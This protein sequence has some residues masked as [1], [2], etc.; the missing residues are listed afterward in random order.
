MAS[1]KI[2]LY[3]KRVMYDQAFNLGTPDGVLRFLKRYHELKARR[4]EGDM[5]A[6]V[7]LM[8][9]HRAWRECEL[10]SRERE[11][12]HLLYWR[13]LS[14]SEASRYLDITIQA[15]KKHEKKAAK[16]LARFIGDY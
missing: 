6:A 1:V 14:K 8:D 11:V 4:N 16:K 2:D 9:F 12:L 3:S 15:V 10:T 13:G 5:E 7:I